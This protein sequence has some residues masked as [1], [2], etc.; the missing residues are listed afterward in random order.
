MERTSRQNLILAVLA[1]GDGATFTP[2][3]IQ[4]LLFLIDRRIPQEVRGPHFN[5]VPYDYGPFDSSIYQDLELL[6]IDEEI[7]IVE[8]P[9]LRW[10]KYRLTPDGLRVGSS[11]LNQFGE[12]TAG[13]IRKLTE[14]VGKLSFAE[15]VGAIYKAYPDMKV[16]SVFRG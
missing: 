13:Y 11:V 7:E 16:N 5:F 6:A 4:K 8:V 15:L 9:N 2:V 10:K 3:R 1:T 14:F 12:D